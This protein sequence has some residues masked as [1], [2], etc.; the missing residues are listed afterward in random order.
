[1]KQAPLLTKEYKTI[2]YVSGP[3][4][5]VNGVLGASFGEIVKITLRDGEVRTGQVLDISEDH[6]VVQVFEGTRG[7]DLVGTTVRFIGEPAR[8]NVSMDMLGRIFS[9][10]GTPRDGGPDIIP[11]AVLD[12]AGTPINPSARDKPA[13]FIQTG[14]S[15]IDGLNTLVRGQKLPIFYRLGAAGEQ[16]RCPDCQAGKSPGRR[17]AVRRSLR[18]DGDHP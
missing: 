10:V 17:G 1:M 2:D 11:E 16:A 12:I 7:I 4:I 15:A 13:D 8:I 5:F 3:L 6:A 18:R 9:G 14:M